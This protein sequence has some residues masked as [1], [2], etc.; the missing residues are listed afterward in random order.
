MK[1][2]KCSVFVGLMALSVGNVEAASFTV[3]PIG[4]AVDYVA[5]SGCIM[6][7]SN[8]TPITLGLCNPTNIAF[9]CDGSVYSNPESGKRAYALALS[10]VMAGKQLQVYLPD[11]TKRTDNNVCVPR[12]VQIIP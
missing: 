2:F 9:D 1:Y 11:D 4:I 8:A 3:T 10:A 5:Y 7:L 6:P 12:Q